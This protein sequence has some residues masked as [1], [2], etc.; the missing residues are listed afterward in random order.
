MEEQNAVIRYRIAVNTK[1]TIVEVL[2]DSEP[3]IMKELMKKARENQSVIFI[4]QFQHI[5]KGFA[6]VSVSIQVVFSLKIINI[7]DISTISTITTITAI[8]AIEIIKTR[9]CG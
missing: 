9:N 5:T 7:I 3:V 2:N 8:M 4:N 1:I 6:A